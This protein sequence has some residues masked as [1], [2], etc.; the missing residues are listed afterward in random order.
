MKAGGQPQSA[1]QAMSA[2]RSRNTGTAQPAGNTA[3]RPDTSV[4][5]KVG[6][7]A[8]HGKWG[9]GTV[10]SVKG[11]G[12]EVEL[13]IAFPDQGVKGLMQKYAPITKA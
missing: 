5:W 4:E 2:L 8:R 3:I 10:V 11:E 12:E 13:K 7:K 6:D 9:I 1:L